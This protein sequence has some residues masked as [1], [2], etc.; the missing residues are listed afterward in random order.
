MRPDYEGVKFYSKEDMTVMYNLEKAD[1]VICNFDKKNEYTDINAVIELYNIKQLYNTGITLPVWTELDYKIRKEKVKS[2]FPV[3]GRFFSEINDFNWRNYE[4]GV[5]SI[6]IDDFWSLFVLFKIFKRVKSETLVSYL[7]NHNASLYSILKQEKIVNAYDEGIAYVLRES[8]NTAQ[9]LSE[10]Y[11]NEE[12][13]DYCFPKSLKPSEYENVFQRYI[14]S[15]DVNPNILYLIMTSKSTA[16]CPLSDKLKLNARHMYDKI[17]KDIRKDASQDDDANQDIIAVGFVNQDEIL[18]IDVK[19]KVKKITYDIGWFEKYLDYPTILN[20]FI[21]TFDMVDRF[22]RSNFVSLE[23]KTGIFEHLLHNAAKQSYYEN[24]YSHS[25]NS[26]YSMQMYYYIDFLNGYGINIEDVFKWFFE[27]Y[28]QK[29]FLAQGFYFASS[30]ATTYLEKC[31]NLASEMESVLKQ[32]KM[33][34]EDGVI[35]REEYEM[36]SGA[37]SINDVPSFIE[38]KYA[39]PNDADINKEMLL[40][41]SKQL[42]LSSIDR[43]G[44]KYSTLF[45]LLYNER[46]SYSEFKYYQT[47]TI[48]RL[49]KRGILERTVDGVVNLVMPDVYILNELYEHEVFCCYKI[50]ELKLI[51]SDMEEKGKL[52]FSKKLFTEPEIAYL[53]YKLNK[54]DYNNGPDLRNRY[55]HGTYPIDIQQQHMDYIELLKIMVLIIIKIND[56]FCEKE[57]FKNNRDISNEKRFKTN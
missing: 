15:D 1:P 36:S 38:N 2:M 23:S 10:K 47:P 35:N 44:N 33:Y 8:N 55:L 14:D 31:K 45:K 39:Y 56:E 20:N 13:V 30:T 24:V 19:D 16:E 49:I 53:N 3:I 6:Y 27:E 41:F 17:W 52:R 37:L 11:L 12:S 50:P 42:V 57:K 29:Q 26:I 5:A 25:M 21:Y 18:K 51:L 28:L 46:V 34:V 32:F 9:I 4:S 22:Y 40:L 7:K 43:V 48:D 54:K